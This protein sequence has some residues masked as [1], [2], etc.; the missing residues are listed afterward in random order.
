MYG[1]IVAWIVGTF[2]LGDVRRVR[3]LA[4]MVWGL[5]HAG[6][7]TYAD[8]GRNM[9]GSSKPASNITRVSKWCNNKLIDPLLIQGTLARVVFETAGTVIAGEKI[10]TVAMDWHSYN[11]GTISALRISLM[12]GSRAIPLLWHEVATTE[13]K[14]VQSQIEIDAAWRLLT[15]RPAGVKLLVLLDAGFRDH[16]LLNILDMAGYYIVRTNA[17]AAVHTDE[18]CW[19]R[20][21]ELPVAVGQV[22]EFGWGYMNAEHPLKTRIVGGRITDLKPVRKGRRHS[23][24]GH[25]KRIHPG[26]CVLATN[27]PGDVFDALDVMRL[28]A[29]RF[30]IEHSFRDIKNA[31]L[32]LDMDHTDLEMATTYSRLM[33]V[34][35]L[36]ELIFW[37]IGSEAESK[38][39]QFDLTPSR[40]K[41]KRRVL[42]LV[43]VGKWY[44]N[45]LEVPVET[46]LVRHLRPAM[47]TVMKTIGRRWQDPAQRLRLATMS[48]TADNVVPLKR[49]C[50]RKAKGAW[51][52]CRKVK[53]WLLEEQPCKRAV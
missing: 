2:Q 10:I 23:P 9:P 36:T 47:R 27:L 15:L 51:E 44:I 33:C 19:T 45:K 26:L 11:N 49:T 1:L 31:T 38:D 4:E 6:C 14:G 30:E 32:G 40:P 41:D 25:Y 28:Y 5:M 24:A 37:L 43:R 46:L 17:A 48:T 21:D 53:L 16:R 22:V 7:I 42:S 8:I 20:T 3:T 39:F 29:R 52:P 18:C 50:G 35:A 12:T 34:V 13:L